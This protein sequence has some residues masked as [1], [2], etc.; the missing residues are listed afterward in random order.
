M[1]R[2]A[3]VAFL[4]VAL[5]VVS[6]WG[7][8]VTDLQAEAGSGQ[9]FDNIECALSATGVL[10]G[11]AGADKR[12][13]A[14]G[15]VADGSV[16]IDVEFAASV[17]DCGTAF[18]HL[19]AGSG[20]GI[21]GNIPTL[22]GFNDDADDDENVRL[23][24]VW[25]EHRFYD[26]V[27]AVKVGK[28][29]LGGACGIKESAFDSNALANDECCQFLS[30]GFVNSLAI[31]FPDD[32]GLGA[33]MWVSAHELIDV[34][35]SV[36]DAEADW[37]NVFNH[38]FAILE[39]DVTPV[40]AGR[41]GNYRLYGWLNDKEHEDIIN[42]DKT[43]Q[44][45]YGF[46]LSCDQEI[47]DCFGV[48]GRYGWQRGSV[49]QVEHAASCGCQLSGSCYGRSDDV[50]GLAYGVAI[51]SD[52]WESVDRASGI[53]TGDEHHVEAYYNCRV[54]DNLSVSPDVQWVA[55]P[56][57]DKDNDDVWVFGVR[58]QMGF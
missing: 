46:G 26:D 22:S 35:V 44:E 52:D 20:E 19:E 56:N 27:V 38:T 51:I 43:H 10:Q 6:A 45:G 48:F 49:Y 28:V 14:D 5:A 7:D 50:I 53:N 17:S 54:N 3:V 40:I 12:L 57:G 33:V 30:S 16:S 41:Q 2:R 18:L 21:D 34:G 1:K 55:N 23:T 37:D 47:T 9:W 29:D 13:S 4:V 24:E 58:A 31:E 8:E 15:D 32:N 36:A 39:V 11:S 25:Y 42:P